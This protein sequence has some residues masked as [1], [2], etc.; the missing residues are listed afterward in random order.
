V[1]CYHK[2]EGGHWVP[3][4]GESGGNPGRGPRRLGRFRGSSADLAKLRSERK[5]KS[6]AHASKVHDYVSKHMSSAAR[7][8]VE[9]NQREKRGGR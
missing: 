7:A 9:K 6:D 1:R 3:T 2:L 8:L 5:A 4:P